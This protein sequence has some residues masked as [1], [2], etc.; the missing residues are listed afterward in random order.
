MGLSPNTGLAC[1]GMQPTSSWG[2]T[3]GAVRLQTV[4]LDSRVDLRKQ[5]DDH[6]GHGGNLRRPIFV[7]NVQGSFTLTFN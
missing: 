7:K 6:L 3:L 1:D 4:N 5:A 2:V